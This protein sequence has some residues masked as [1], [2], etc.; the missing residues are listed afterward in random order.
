MIDSY[1][2]ALLKMTGDQMNPAMRHADPNHP[3]NHPAGV[4][5]PSLPGRMTPSGQQG[6]PG[7]PQQ[8]NGSHPLSHPAPPTSGSGT[9]A[10]GG[11]PNDCPNLPDLNFDPTIM[12]GESTQHNLDVSWVYSPPSHP[13]DF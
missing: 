12:N 7:T 4:R 11:S 13:P 10:M 1:G 9:G 2:N 3:A 5:P 6:G 8:Q